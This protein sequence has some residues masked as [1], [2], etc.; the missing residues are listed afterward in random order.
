MDLATV[1]LFF[2][3]LGGAA[4]DLLPTRIEEYPD[5]S[6]AA[7]AA[8]LA[9]L[10]HD[11][12]TPD[13]RIAS[14]LLANDLG[15]LGL[16]DLAR[17]ELRAL[18]DSPEIGAAAFVSLVR[19]LD[20]DRDDEAL[21]AAVKRARWADL[22]GDEIAEVAFRIARACVRERRYAEARDWLAQVPPAS[23]EYLPSRYVL[24]QAEYALDRVPQALDAIE[25]MFRAPR[26]EPAVGWLQDRAALLAGEML[27]EIGLYADAAAVLEWPAASSPFHSRAA[28]E[29]AT[30]RALAKIATSNA[31]EDSTNVERVIDDGGLAAVESPEARARIAGELEKAWPSP[32]L[33]NERR[34]SAAGAARRAY[35]R[36]RGFG[37]RQALDVAWRS[38][39]P[40]I[41]YGALRAKRPAPPP[42]A[43]E[44]SPDTRFFFTP[45]PRVANLLT[46]IALASEAAGQT[47]SDC[48]A[49]A[50]AARAA[51][52]LAEEAPP[53]SAA[54][55]AAASLRCD[56][57]EP[58]SV[59]SLRAKLERA[60][61]EETLR[62]ERTIH[63]RR[64]F[65]EER[66]AAARIERQAM[67]AAARGET[68]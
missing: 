9:R 38:L 25:V 66:L 39:P 51:R 22:A 43:P 10:A 23:S 36:S 35:E 26:R 27:T 41:V 62:R 67:L 58:I 46:A 47:Q 1:V 8:S 24:A 4:G 16:R 55:L 56:A 14:F 60:I 31:A 44:L 13:E 37:W 32:L 18:V 28:R 63:E 48:G 49:R 7:S 33:R 45:E 2:P 19:L 57:P 68:R 6:A 59:A 61:E 34:R 12:A 11:R 21:L 20:E 40:V 54:E 50:I 15:E 17:R 29:A 30:A 3:L 52:V 64:Y 42:K 5:R 53:P 65:L